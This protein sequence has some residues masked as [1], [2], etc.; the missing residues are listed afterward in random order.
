MSSTKTMLFDAGLR[1]Q[2]RLF[3]ALAHPARLAIL[4]YL[5]ETRTCITGDIA[6]EIPLGRTTVNQHLKELRDAN[7]IVGTTEGVKKNYCLN[8]GQIEMLK[9]L[10][11]EFFNKIDLEN[12]CCKSETSKDENTDPMHR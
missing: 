9:T 5:A 8:K 7:L 4:V 10:S 11:D 6:D 3:K 12:P 2:A 1:E